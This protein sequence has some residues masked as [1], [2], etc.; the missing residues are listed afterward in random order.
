MSS[1]KRVVETTPKISI[2]NVKEYV[3]RRN[4]I[5]QFMLTDVFGNKSPYSVKT[6][7]SKCYF[8]GARPWFRCIQCN[9]RAGVLYLNETGTHLFCRECSNLRYRSQTAGGSNRLLMRC[10]DADERAETV[11]EGP[12]RVKFL[13]KGVPTRRFKRFLK[14]RQKAEQLSRVFD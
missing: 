9:N 11:F 8:G 13:Y 1:S 14:Y 2:S 12:Q 7:A 4:S 6:T 10:F 3:S 5:V